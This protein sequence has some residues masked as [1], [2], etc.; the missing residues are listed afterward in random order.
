MASSTLRSIRPSEPARSEQADAA[1]QAALESA[2]RRLT[3]ERRILR[4]ARLD[5]ADRPDWPGTDRR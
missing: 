2:G 3:V 4:R 1:R 5:P